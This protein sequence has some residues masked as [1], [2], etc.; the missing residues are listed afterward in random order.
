M[1]SPCKHKWLEDASRDVCLE[2][3]VIQEKMELWPGASTDPGKKHDEKQQAVVVCRFCGE[4]KPEYGLCGACEAR[5]QRTDSLSDVSRQTRPYL[6]GSA[7]LSF[8]GDPLPVEAQLSPLID[9]T[10]EGDNREEPAFYCIH[11]RSLICSS[12]HCD[13]CGGWQR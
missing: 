9:W 1:M 6:P 2:C 3:G 11:C 4:D 7:R 5:K 8:N 13:V 10:G 12:R